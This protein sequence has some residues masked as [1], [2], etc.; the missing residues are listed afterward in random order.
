MNTFRSLYGI[1][2][3]ALIAALLTYGCDSTTSELAP[4]ASPQTASDDSQAEESQVRETALRAY[5]A[6]AQGFVDG[7]FSGYLAMLSPSFEFSYPLG[8][9]GGLYTGSEGYQHMVDKANEHAEQGTRLTMEPPSG[10]FVDGDRVAFLFES[11]GTFGEYEYRAHNMIVFGVS[12]GR[13]TAFRE[14]FGDVDTGFVCSLPA[15]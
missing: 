6:W 9:H 11:H 15:Q 7:D 3:A 10:V 5:N 12:E 4:D 2:L 1:Q 13:I 14:F 8:E